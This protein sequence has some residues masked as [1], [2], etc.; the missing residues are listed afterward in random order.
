[1]HTK[2]EGEDELVPNVP[3]KYHRAIDVRNAS[4]GLS[5]FD[6]LAI[7]VVGM[8]MGIS[9]RRPKTNLGFTTKDPRMRPAVPVTG[10]P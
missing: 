7:L 2:Q 8:W 1:M 10:P 5:D 4:A 6:F 9:R 3:F